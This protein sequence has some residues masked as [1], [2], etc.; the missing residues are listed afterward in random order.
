[1]VDCVAEVKAAAP[2]LSD[3][4]VTDLIESLQRVSGERQAEAQL[5]SADERLFDAGERVKREVATAAFIERRNRL[6]N[7]T[8]QARILRF[9]DEMD[10]AIGDPV[11]AVEGMLVGFT[12]RKG[13]EVFGTRRSVDTEG[14]TLFNKYFNELQREIR[15][16]GVFDDWRSNHID[17]DIAREL[18][19]LSLREPT[20]AATNNQAAKKVAEAIVKVRDKAIAAENKAGAW[21]GHLEGFITT[22]THDP[23]RLNRAGFDEWSR[24]I[25]PRLDIQR[26]FGK[27]EADVEVMETLKNIFDTLQNGV[28][29]KSQGAEID[30]A[31]AFKGPGNLAKRISQHRVLHFKDADSAFDYHMEFGTR[32]LKESIVKELERSAHNTA[33]MRAFGTNPENMLNRVVDKLKSKHKD[34]PK[35]IDQLRSRRLEKRFKEVNG[36]TRIPLR[37]GGA[38]VAAAARALESVTKLGGA[39]LSAFADTMFTAA[40]FRAQGAPLL[41][42]YADALTNL[43]RGFNT[44]AKRELFDLVD[45]GIDG[46]LGS[47]A[48]RFTTDDGP[49]GMI[50]KGQRL[51]FKL[52]LLQ[53]WTD[54]HQRG[55]YV[56]MAR[57]LAQMKSRPFDQL[58]DKQ[59]KLFGIYGIDSAKWDEI[60]ANPT[61]FRNKEL[62]LPD[63]ELLSAGT[64][65]AYRAYLQ[66]RTTFAVP[67]P[68]A[69]ERSMANL[70]TQPGDIL[71]EAVRF[72][73]Q[74]KQFP[75]TAARKIVPNVYQMGGGLALVEL[76]LGTTIMGYVAQTAKE[77][78]KGRSPRDPT[79]SN[80][81][82]AAALQGGGLGIY[83]DFLF[84]E[85]NRFGGGL[86]ESLVGPTG[87]RLADLGELW[88]RFREGDDTAASLFRFA[89]N[90]VPGINLFYT[91]IA[92]DYLLLYQAQEKLNPGYLR[93]YERRI[94][95]E[96]N[97]TFI[98]PPRQAL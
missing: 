90:A 84:G 10:D 95:R 19:D 33:M 12:K 92:L 5:R 58:P 55:V 6:I 76:M 78:A 82:T 75:I 13:R 47:I 4:E 60:R 65:Q 7:A 41:R 42:G 22:Q 36:T 48:S 38:H 30:L 93:R 52:N 97:Q 64:D 80:T 26:T 86:A 96:N 45:V 61:K 56:M 17:Q 15:A 46:Q 77:L 94:K 62:L 16:R 9:A 37:V 28:H 68:G 98:I 44:K 31:T 18:Y 51:F 79:L 54:A 32:N 83:G 40:E 8:V 20:G 59:Q 50:S 53:P 70:G 39:T 35:I 1:M 23:W 73:M 88:A 69:R 25:L 57:R 3:D 11:A 91:R 24:S 72:G 27:R 81:W 29:I 87:G 63:E 66:D 49:P 14:T 71:G 34:N 43:G 85:F 89:V 67:I 21:K 2:N 74:F